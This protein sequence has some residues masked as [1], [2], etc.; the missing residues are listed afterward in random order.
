MASTMNNDIFITDYFKRTE[1]Q[2]KYKDN[3]N[4]LTMLDGMGGEVK[5]NAFFKKL[6]FTKKDHMELQGYY[7]QALTYLSLAI[8]GEKKKSNFITIKQNKIKA[9]I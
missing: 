9:F 4:Q 1:E 2:E 3:F 7:R 5:G 6:Y 8:E